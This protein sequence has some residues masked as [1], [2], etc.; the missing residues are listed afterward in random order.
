MIIQLS[1]RKAASGFREADEKRNRHRASQIHEVQP[2][3]KERRGK[4]IAL[5][6]NP[7]R[8]DPQGSFPGVTP[9]LRILSGLDQN[10]YL[11]KP[12]ELTKKNVSSAGS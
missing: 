1:W 4:S 7:C 9:V 11:E 12:K 6:R 10:S 5:D 3:L 2:S 8:Q